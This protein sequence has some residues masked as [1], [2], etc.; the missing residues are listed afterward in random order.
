[1]GE[2][3]VWRMFIQICLALEVI[4]E[5]GIVHADLKPSNVLSTGSNYY[6]K[7]TDFGISQNLC[8]GCGLVH[9]T[10]GTMP[11]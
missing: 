4:H 3:R 10:S 2:S 5:K 1:M 7:I 6:P 9:E 11:Y 8:K